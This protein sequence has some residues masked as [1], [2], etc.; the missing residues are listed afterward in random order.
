MEEWSNGMVAYKGGRKD[1]LWVNEKTSA[2]ELRMLGED[3]MREGLDNRV[4][5]YSLTYDRREV[6]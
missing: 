4:M 3:V 1:C 6:I 2:L 5:W